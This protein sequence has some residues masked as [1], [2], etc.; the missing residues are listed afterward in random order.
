MVKGLFHQG[1]Q[2]LTAVAFPYKGRP[3]GDAGV[4]IYVG[5]DFHHAG[6]AD[7]L[8]GLFV[9]AIKIN[10]LLCRCVPE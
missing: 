9:F 1:Q 8:A 6:K 3:D 5:S 7:G 10:H 2:N 4:L